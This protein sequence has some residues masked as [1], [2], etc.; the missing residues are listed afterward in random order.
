MRLS[1]ITINL[2]NAD[3]LRKTLESVKNQIFR[4]FE[5]IVVD[6]NSTDDSLI[7]IRE[8]E[9][10]LNEQPA[11]PRRFRWISEA[12]NGKYAA[13]NKGIRMA[14]G[15]Y[16]LFLNSGDYLY[17]P[18]VL[19]EFFALNYDEDIVSGAVETFSAFHKDRKVYNNS[20]PEKLSLNTF[21]NVSLNHQGTFIRRSLFTKF[22]LY[23][24]DFSIVS[25]TEFFLKTICFGGVSYRIIYKVISCFNIDGISS[26]NRDLRSEESQKML[27][28]T[29]PP[30]VLADYKDN[31]ISKMETIYRYGLSRIT[32]KLLLYVVRIYEKIF[33]NRRT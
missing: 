20:N 16:L 33:I 8:F 2:N 13:M 31:F 9:G 19:E 27:K 12:D 15:E 30:L 21:L 25:D 6:G 7:R 18:E 1:I 5:F 11:N 22:G 23:S 3:G 10:E 32:F 17:T 28:R 29:V 24:E 4:D 14:I 26:S